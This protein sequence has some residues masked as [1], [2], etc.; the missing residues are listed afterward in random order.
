MRS[1]LEANLSASDRVPEWSKKK[2]ESAAAAAVAATDD[3]EEG[4]VAP[5]LPPSRP[6]SALVPDKAPPSPA[7][8]PE[9][10]IRT[11]HKTSWPAGTS[12]VSAGARSYLKKYCTV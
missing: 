12:K 2:R 4:A 8:V 5:A 10:S 11:P 9:D 3:E 6:E 7:L 1:R